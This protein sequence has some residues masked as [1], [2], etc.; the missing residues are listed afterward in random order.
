V[1][2]K[3]ARS[4]PVAKCIHSKLRSYIRYEHCIASTFRRAVS[5]LHAPKR[6]SFL[7]AAASPQQMPGSPKR[8]DALTPFGSRPSYSSGKNENSNSA[9]LNLFAVR[10]HRTA[11]SQK[12]GNTEHYALC[13][14]AG[15]LTFR[16]TM[17][18]DQRYCIPWANI[19]RLI[20]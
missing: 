8:I 12:A 5:K 6:R 17:N 19:H 3:K 2:P 11:R 14:L 7:R 4:I 10:L 18:Q 15:S 13:I 20:A 16:T 1:A 9:L